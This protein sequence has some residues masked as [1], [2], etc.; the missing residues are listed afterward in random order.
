MTLNTFQH[1]WNRSERWAFVALPPGVLPASIDARQA[2]EAISAFARVGT[3]QAV[4]LAYRSAAGRWPVDLPLAIGLGNAAYEMGSREEARRVFE[5]ATRRHP[6]SGA[7]YNNL[8]QALSDL[9]LYGPA[10]AA[11]QRAV[12]LGEPW[13]EAA[14]QTLAKI[15]QREARVRQK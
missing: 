13:R 12:D 5:E 10:R 8:P 2:V 1:T 15:H 11:A 6:D 14:L 9:G 4:Y 3:K 7:A